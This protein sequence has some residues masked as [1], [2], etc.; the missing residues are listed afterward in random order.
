MLGTEKRFDNYK[1]AIEFLDD[2][3][4][5][6]PDSRKSAIVEKVEITK[7][8]FRTE[9]KTTIITTWDE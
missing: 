4:R 7:R 1:S 3:I 9:Q 2:Y 8:F 5:N 6:F